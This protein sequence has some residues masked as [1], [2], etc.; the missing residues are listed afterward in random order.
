MPKKV[1]TSFKTRA[2]L[3]ILVLG[4]LCVSCGGLFAQNAY[5]SSQYPNADDSYTVG[6]INTQNNTFTTVRLPPS[7]GGPGT[8][9]VSNDGL[10]AYIA[11]NAVQQDVGAIAVVDTTTNSV[12]AM[13]SLA[14]S[15]IPNGFYNISLSPDGS[16]LYG[17]GAILTSSGITG[18]IGVLNTATGA[19]IQVLPIPA[20]YVNNKELTVIGSTLYAILYGGNS[21][22]ILSLAAIDLAT[23]S[24]TTNLGF[25]G[26]V[27]SSLLPSPDGT[28]IYVL[29]GTQPFI[30]DVGSNLLA[31]TSYF[32][33]GQS[34]SF[35]PDETRLYTVSLSP[36][37]DFATYGVQAEQIIASI[38]IGTLAA[39][40]QIAMTPNGNVVYILNSPNAT[41]S[42]VNTA[43]N[44]VVA[45]IALGTTNFTGIAIQPASPTVGASL[46]ELGK[47]LG[48]CACSKEIDPS[49]APVPSPG[50]QQ[51]SGD[52][53][54]ISSGN[55]FEQ[56]TDY[57]TS[58]QN[59]LA[60]SRY[61]NSLSAA[62][63]VKT[64]ASSL[65]VNWRSDFD[66]YINLQSST[67]V[68]AER[69]NGQQLNFS[70]GASGWIADPDEDLKLTNSGSTWTLTDSYDTV[71]TYNAVSASEAQLV[72]V[73]LRNGYTQNLSYSG[74]LLMS[75]T[76][77]Y[78]RSLNLTYGAGLLQTVTTP[79]GSTLNYSFATATGGSQLTGVAYSTVPQTSISY[80][81]ENPSFPF[82][83]TG[84][85]DENG[86][87]YSTWSYDTSGRALTSQLGI[88]ANLTSF[89]YNADG[90][91]TVTNALGVQDTYRF[92]TLQGVPKASEI[93]RAA[94]FTTAAASKLFTYDSN[95]YLAST[96]DWNGNLT[97][98]VNDT[99]GDPTTI[100]E[101]VDSPV[102]RTTT[103]TYDPVWVHLPDTIV[104]PELTTSYTY[105]ASGDPLTK[106]FIDTTKTFKPY[107]TNGQKRIWNFTWANFLL[108][109]A[110][111][112][113]GN[114]TNYSY[115]ATGALIKIVNP[116]K[117][118][119][120]ITQYTGGGYPEIFVDPNN[121]STTIAY[122]A[123]QRILSSTV[124]GTGGT[125]LTTY[126][127]DPA[128]E[129]TKV[130]LP[131]NSY[132][133][134]LYDTAHRVTQVT[135][136]LGNYLLYT[137]DAL[138][139][140]TQIN[141][142]DSA[143]KLHRQHSATFDALGRMLTDVGGL[144]QTTSYSFDPDGNIL[145]IL[146]PLLHLTTRTFDALNRLSTSTDA[147]QGITRFSYDPHDR[148]LTVT[149]PDT[150]VTTFVYDGFGD[151]IE[152][153]SPDSGT[154]VYHFD[155]DA[156]LTKKT[157][158][159]SII[160][161]NTY[162]ALD[163]VLTTTY[164]ADAP[165]NVAYTY[166]QTGT[167]YGF[168]IGRLTSLTDAAGSLTRS[169][170]ERAN[171]LT[172]QRIGGG[173]TF[174]TKY[175]YDPAS[176]ISGITYPDGAVVGNSYNTAGY[177]QRVSARP[178]GATASSTIA[179]LS[180][181][182]FGAI[183]GAAYGN[184]ISESWAFD[185]DYRPTSL[186]DATSSAVLQ[187][188]NY[189]YDAANNVKTIGDSVNKSDS[190]S[191][192]YDVLNRLTTGASAS[193]GY[194]SLKWVYD[195]NGNLTSQTAN[196]ITTTYVLTAGSN[197]LMSLTAGGV[198]TPIAT[199]ANGNITSIPPVSSTT[200]A[201]FAYN[202]ANRLSS[203]TG[204]T[205]AATF[206]YD[207][208][209]RRFSKA[210]PSSPATFFVYAQDGSLLEENDN[211]ANADYLYAD[212]RPISVLQPGA[213]PA[214]DQVN[215]IL[216][217]RLGTPQHAFN[218]SG[219]SVWSTTYQPYGET[220]TVSGSIT[221]NLRLPGQHFDAET[222]FHYNFN[223]D[224]MPNVGRY[225]EVDPAGLTGGPS[226]FLYASANPQKFVDPSGLDVV[227]V[228]NP[229]G[230]P[231]AG[232]P[233]GHIALLVGND[234]TDNTGWLFYSVNGGGPSSNNNGV[235]YNN[236]DTFGGAQGSYSQGYRIPSS[237]QQDSWMN[238]AAVNGVKSG[239]NFRLRNCA[240]LVRSVLE[241]GGIPNPDASEFL[242]GAEIPKDVFQAI[243]E[244]NPGGKLIVINQ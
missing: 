127:I 28:E 119:T 110:K 129:L 230:A 182:P 45:T 81:Y 37:S 102:A 159:L 8:I 172:E 78:G 207:A 241:A 27:I 29:S 160:T 111:T 121:V 179:S 73:Q 25:P 108:A 93:D 41:V 98:Y 123:R 65:G 88:G 226:T 180:H 232:F 114:L 26:D 38:P 131:D 117:Q 196:A 231:V 20:Y 63:L 152:Q 175:A 176:R 7:F 10:R 233:Q 100:N 177:L 12:I 120:N 191:M 5:L 40:N 138:G 244:A 174:T 62:G 87:R 46:L 221:Q 70:L 186:K 139:D 169:W 52:P 213:S 55:V 223:R 162:D 142:Y 167:A 104:T 64:F 68:V 50:G 101:A 39:P 115:S 11:S 99:H 218:S 206:I 190:Q 227:I 53:V 194:G 56:V 235:S 58:G 155:A 107:L 164:P 126:T 201:T 147:N 242:S 132:L 35:S 212:A 189:G 237:N 92:I 214:A 195:K 224:Y 168:G 75:V 23:G 33:I 1:I 234:N 31:L 148:A 57:Q 54:T 51:T 112:P 161:N 48:D 109:S 163:R 90:S 97:T 36:A 217:D 79:D 143:G 157:D 6:V 122:D 125:F 208:F 16:T 67:T 188:L 187:N 178:V 171:M 209:G 145:T 60:F 220:G 9:A 72:S 84:L 103:V 2:A 4:V 34:A 181:L 32:G 156:N 193:G 82:A 30:Y 113:N 13:Y 134:Y 225:L 135:D 243:I 69:A 205:L 150:N 85:I 236:I 116:L 140:R 215:Y 24:I 95:G 83:L 219:A 76:D 185:L 47:L 128:S 18:A 137:L 151:T 154:S 105:D 203:V 222:G 239:Y 173:K 22:N 198:T 158:A 216:A 59:A 133:A 165:E 19:L 96:T 238:T 199:N 91:R 136:T 43:T 202:N 66:R 15:A 118:A 210:N 94:T 61:Y 211:G 89:A 77:S 240:D 42:A 71:E 80:L 86:N 146:D 170:D 228:I 192:T 74:T 144:G 197:R 130:T 166:D 106:T 204:T 14:G 44:E 149:D 153:V 3:L 17:V 184:G 141:T 124:S 200:P 49:L 21:Q 183:T 229:N